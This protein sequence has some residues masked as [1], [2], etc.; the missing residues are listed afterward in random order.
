MKI[1]ILPDVGEACSFLADDRVGGLRGRGTSQHLGPT[2]GR[3]LAGALEGVGVGASHRLEDTSGMA[4]VSP[5]CYRGSPL[6]GFVAQPA[7]SG[8]FAD[9]HCPRAKLASGEG[10]RVLGESS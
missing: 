4:C 1:I 8:H 10:E 7:S 2:A 9:S 3:L 5:V 6:S